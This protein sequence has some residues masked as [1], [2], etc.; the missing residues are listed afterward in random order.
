MKTNLKENPMKASMSKTVVFAAM[1]ACVVVAAVGSASAAAN[2][3]T[4]KLSVTDFTGECCMS[5]GEVV[6]IEEGKTIRPVV[7]VWSFDFAEGVQDV[8]FAGLSVNG[9]PC[10]TESWGARALYPNPTESFS[11]TTFQWV[12]LPGDGVLVKGLNSFEVCGGGKSSST[13]EI[14]IGDNALTVTFGQ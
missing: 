11:S 6:T 7:V 4:R 14:S 5:F 2:P 13:D 1:L 9:G 8:Y 3:I 12:I 10:E